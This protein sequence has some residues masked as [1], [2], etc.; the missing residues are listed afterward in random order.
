MAPRK[1]SKPVIS[2]VEL[3]RML[4]H[5]QAHFRRY[6]Y[7]PLPPYPTTN[8]KTTGIVLSPH[9]HQI[10]LGYGKKYTGDKLRAL[11][12][13]RGCGKRKIAA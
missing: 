2:I 4:R 11:R 3:Q 7:V 9:Y 1:P 6:A 10:K 5:R 13:E 8:F 12:A